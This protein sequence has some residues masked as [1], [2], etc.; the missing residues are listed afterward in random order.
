[1]FYSLTL[2]VLLFSYPALT[3]PFNN[4]LKQ[5]LCPAGGNACAP[6]R[7]SSKPETPEPE[8]PTR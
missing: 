4:I 7:D 5:S 6:F 1:M 2:T 3:V 8:L